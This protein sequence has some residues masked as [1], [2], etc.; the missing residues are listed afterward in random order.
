MSNIVNFK[1][2]KT[3]KFNEEHEVILSLEDDSDSDS[4]N[5]NGMQFTFE[6]EEDDA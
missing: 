1:K 6:L 3:K 5:D 4:S 2:A